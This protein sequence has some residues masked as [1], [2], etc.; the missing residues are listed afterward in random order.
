MGHR[1]SLFD[2]MEN[3]RPLSLHVQD[4]RKKQ[5]REERMRDGADAGKFMSDFKAHLENWTE[6]IG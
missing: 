2:A 6:D 1:P 5:I 3:R 4:C